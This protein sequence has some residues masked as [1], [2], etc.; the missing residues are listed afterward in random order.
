MPGRP[1]LHGLACETSRPG[2]ASMTFLNLR[3]KPASPPSSR[4]RTGNSLPPRIMGKIIACFTRAKMRE[5]SDHR[6]A[7]RHSSPAR[8]SATCGVMP[9]GCKL[10]LEAHSFP[11]SR[12]FPGI[13][14][15]ANACCAIAMDNLCFP[16]LPPALLPG[17][18]RGNVRPLSCAVRFT[19][20]QVCK[21]GTG[22][23]NTRDGDRE[24]R[25]PAVWVQSLDS[26]SRNAVQ[27]FSIRT[28]S[29]AG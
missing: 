1:R 11:I 24:Y 3:P 19:P 5:A 10:A 27:A 13:T 17:K 21:P 8:K 4:R 22:A 12:E 26:C 7:T 18:T 28:S 25:G 15:P 14:M 6:P 23:Q 2:P 29:G 20:C 9:R 16:A